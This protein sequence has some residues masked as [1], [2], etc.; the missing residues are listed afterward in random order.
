MHI[1]VLVSY[2]KRMT[3]LS[4][5]ENPNIPT[6]YPC[7]LQLSTF[8][9]IAA[10]YISAY[11]DAD[12]IPLDFTIGASSNVRVEAVENVQF[13]MGGA[14]NLEL[15]TTQ[16]NPSTQ[17]R[18]DEK[19]LDISAD[20]TST[21]LSFGNNEVIFL[22]G[23]ANSTFFLNDLKIFD[24]NLFKVFDTTAADGFM[25]NDAVN[26]NGNVL[27]R[28]DLI[29]SSNVYANGSLV[30]R[31][32][33][34]FT[35]KDLANLALND[36]MRVGYVFN[37]NS[38]DQLELIKYTRFFNGLP[39]AQ[40]KVAVF[41][42]N[43]LSPTDTNAYP[44]VD[45]FQRLNGV[46]FETGFTVSK[47][48][49]SDAPL[50]GGSVVIN[51]A[52]TT[53]T[54]V[55]LSTSTDSLSMSFLPTP[56]TTAQIGIKGTITLVERSESGRTL[57]FPDG[58]TVLTSV[59]TSTTS[60]PSGGYAID[61]ITYTVIGVNQISA[62]Y[63]N[64]STFTPPGIFYTFW[65]KSNTLASVWTVFATGNNNTSVTLDRSTGLFTPSSPL[66]ETVLSDGTF[67]TGEYRGLIINY[68][69]T[70]D[71]VNFLKVK[72]FDGT[73][74][75]P[76]K[77]YGASRGEYGYFI[78]LSALIQN[79]YTLENLGFYTET[80]TLIQEYA[81]A[82][83]ASFPSL[84]LHNVC[85]ALSSTNTIDWS[86]AVF[87]SHPSY[88]I[89][90][91][92]NCVVTSG[93]MPGTSTVFKNM[94]TAV[95]TTL[96]PYAPRTSDHQYFIQKYHAVTGAILWNCLAITTY[97]SDFGA[98]SVDIAPNG[99]VLQMYGK[100]NN[101]LSASQ[102]DTYIDS[103]S[104]INTRTRKVSA[105]YFQS[106]TVVK[107]NS[108]GLFVWAADMFM[109]T[110]QLTQYASSVTATHSIFTNNNNVVS[111]VA[112]EDDGDI[113]T[114][115]V[116]NGNDTRANAFC[117]TPTI[118]GSGRLVF[119]IC[120]GN[121]GNVLWTTYIGNGYHNYPSYSQ[122]SYITRTPDNGIVVSAFT[123]WDSEFILRNADG[124]IHSTQSI[125]PG[126]GVIYVKYNS[127]GNV[128]WSAKSDSSVGYVESP[129]VASTDD[130]GVLCSGNVYGGEPGTF[131]DAAGNTRAV[132]ET[133]Y[134][135]LN[136]DGLFVPPA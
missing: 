1:F 109:S 15:Y 84:K 89:A 96:S 55:E 106:Y 119:I 70:G 22:A 41:G 58:I 108:T 94:S 107:Y 75:R 24:S 110:A 44:N 112:F 124:S 81:S 120:H 74:N 122:R 33:A 43:G 127:A 52:Q 66:E 10:Q 82:T 67:V 134:I 98:M 46:S 6:I 76:V 17:V 28:G 35:N 125:V 117:I 56:L 121:D 101:M 126:S 100:Q 9:T 93:F 131:Y 90:A 114:L 130:E 2:V 8:S 72:C 97:S 129:F 29:V 45:V 38:N 116:Y 65:N 54:V 19:V 128:V 18:L 60:A 14:G 37:I 105:N 68:S 3:S 133:F 34:L 113:H 63:Q 118:S 88:Y 53:N 80:D 21:T 71:I 26:F 86:Y 91:N 42:M 115:E 123:Y 64:T 7:L 62:T 39:D 11:K 73:D 12:G 50:S 83:N 92:S 25:F 16:Y 103:A 5:L 51:L 47:I 31:E 49:S 77:V 48:G 99:D 135:K 79:Q 32:L 27:F 30:G 13:F 4:V 57:N 59:V 136:K 20:P 111:A 95:E 40:K 85:A 61:T 104:T 23:D 87:S 132:M 78:H 102:G 69:P 36:P